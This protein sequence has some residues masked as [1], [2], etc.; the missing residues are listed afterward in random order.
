MKT[1]V[2]PATAT[3]L[4]M[5]N[6]YAHAALNSAEHPIENFTRSISALYIAL[7]S[8]SLITPHGNISPIERIKTYMQG[9]YPNGIPYWA[10][11]KIRNQIDDKDICSFLIYDRMASY[12]QA[13][14]DFT[15]SYPY[16]VIP[17]EFVL[18]RPNINYSISEDFLKFGV[19]NNLDIKTLKNS[20][21]VQY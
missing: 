16:R 8:C 10:L 12:R 21:S 14:V 13:R 1:L 2:I 3:I 11:P 19:D 7:S 17:L 5:G 18:S 6:A 4:F 15:I 20:F 9:L